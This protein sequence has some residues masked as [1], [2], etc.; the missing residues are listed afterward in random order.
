MRIMVF[1]EYFPPKLGSDRRIYELMKRLSREHE[2]H[3]VV[4]P[5]FRMLSNK[6]RLRQSRF[7]LGKREVTVMHHSIIAHYIPISRFIMNLW[8]R[9]FMMAF[10]LTLLS[11]LPKIL[12]SAWKINPDAVVLNYPSPYTGFLGYIVG[13]RLLRKY[14]LLDFNDLIAQYT[15]HLLNLN[16]R[17]LAAKFNVFVQ[18]FIT[19][20]SDRVV[21]PTNYIKRYADILVDSKKKVVVIPNGADTRHFDPRRYSKKHL[22]RQ[23]KLTNKRV[24]LY[25][26]R[27]E[28]WAGVD[29][30]PHC[31]EEF[32]SR[33]LNVCFMIV[34]S[35]TKK[36]LPFSENMLAVGEVP[37]EKVP[38]T[39]EVADVVLVPFPDNE[40]SRAASPLKLF[41]GM[42]MRKVVLASRVDGINEVVSHNENGVLVDTNNVTDWVEAILNILNDPSLASEIGKNARR[43]VEEK[44]DWELLASRYE[45]VFTEE[46]L[47]RS[48]AL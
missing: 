3:F 39:L 29:I 35:G 1:V 25:C 45:K 10:F 37:Y 41:E 24:C 28:S 38:E 4:F 19:R 40:V 2:V 5:P 48:H 6:L 23:L 46:A 20:S 32:K 14:V 9:S 21:V 43:T 44:Y 42:A 47:F 22:R 13:K 17:S 18:K 30:I 7:H 36:K 34:G 31:C 12:K 15:I 11:L 16:P 33:N 27:L 8:K 26:G